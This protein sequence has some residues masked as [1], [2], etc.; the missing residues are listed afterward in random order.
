MNALYVVRRVRKLKNHMVI[1][2]KKDYF[3]YRLQALAILRICLMD[4][5]KVRNYN[6]YA[7]EELLNRIELKRYT[8]ALV[9]HD[10]FLTKRGLI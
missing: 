3:I 7:P 2:D 4:S 1:M 10:K 9:N 5:E 8:K 6:Q